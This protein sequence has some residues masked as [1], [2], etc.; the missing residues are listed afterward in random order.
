MAAKITKGIWP[1]VA[2]I[3]LRNR[4]FILLCIVG[5]T[6]FMGLQWK[7]IRFS[8]TESIILPEHHPASLQYKDFT[9]LFGEEGNAI[10]LAIKDSA[11]F[12]PE[13]FNRWNRLSKQLEAFPEIDYAI[14]LENLKVL[15]K[16]NENQ[17]FAMEPFLKGSPGSEREV[18]SIKNA[19][20]T[21]L[22][23]YDGLI[24][25]P[26]SGT[27]RTI[28]YMDKDIV[29]TAVRNEFILNDLQDLIVDFEAETQ[30]DVRV[31]GM[32]YI[33]SWNTKTMVDVSGIF[34]VAALV[35][36]SLIFYFF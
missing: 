15:V 2:R 13:N 18:D 9:D 20:F 31:S 35:I 6:V 26:E 10:V 3:I 28:A 21:E 12:E 29:N 32:P 7:N 27:I 36:T 22:P 25:N 17:A 30:M 33:R 1:K 16:D 11:L 19:L 4:I 24:Y 14:S 8:N 5:F 34:I 23:F